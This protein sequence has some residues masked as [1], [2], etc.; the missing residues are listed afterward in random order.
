MSKNSQFVA[1]GGY[2]WLKIE[3]PDDYDRLVEILDASFAP[4][5]IANQLK[6][7]ISKVG[8]VLVEHDYID[9]DYSSTY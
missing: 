8:A 7:N 1:T 4:N 3:S 9:K 2:S 6:N 5:V